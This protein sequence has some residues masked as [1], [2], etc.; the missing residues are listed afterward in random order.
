MGS[1][2]QGQECPHLRP[3]TPLKRTACSVSGE[4][5]RPELLRIASLA[6]SPS[7]SKQSS[8]GEGTGRLLVQN[9]RG[10]ESLPRTYKP[11]GNSK[12]ENV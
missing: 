12:S 1:D 9:V 5:Q 4:G 6:R 3:P 7:M 10:K 11:A 2:Q 8:C